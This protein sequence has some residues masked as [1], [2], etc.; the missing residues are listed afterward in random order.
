MKV[1]RDYL[2]MFDVL[3]G[4]L[5]LVIALGHHLSFVNG[6]LITVESESRGIFDWSATVIALFFIIA[7]YQF[8]PTKNIKEYVKRQA[9]LLL[10]PYGIAVVISAVLRSIVLWRI[11]GW[12]NI[13]DIST[14]V[15]G[16]LYGSIQ[17][18]EV[19][20]IWTATV[21]SLWF[22]PTTFLS[23][24]FFQLLWRIKDSRVTKAVIWVLTIAAVSFPDAF[25]IQLPFFCVQ[26]C[27]VLG[28]MEIGRLLKEKKILYQKLSPVFVMV[29]CVAFVLCHL[30]SDANVASNIWKWWMIDYLTACASSVVIL[31]FYLWSGLG[32]MKYVGFLEYVGTYSLL[33]FCVHGVE[34]LIVPWDERLG[35]AIVAANEK[36]Q[37]PL[38]LI[39]V[40]I[41]V[42][43]VLYTFA[44]CKVLNSLMKLKYRK[45][46][47]EG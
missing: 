36:L 20:H 4:I 26:S 2:G 5:M 1:K 8:K 13:R 15:L 11:E 21:V 41:Y 17:D 9:V 3:K 18:V 37:L 24:L 16:G 33:F 35:T 34:L 22:L 6:G 42:I 19:F 46:R 31:K 28:F 38:W 23:G 14:L 27:A 29:S 10:V 25:E 32:C 12:F 39:A 47:K 45:K 43:R 44:G 7:G 30:F 40:L